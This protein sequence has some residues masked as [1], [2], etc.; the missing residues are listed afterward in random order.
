M[1]Q[2]GYQ[3]DIRITRIDDDTR[4]LPGVVE[5]NVLPGQTGIGALVHSVARREIGSQIWLAGADIDRVGIGGRQSDRA[6]RGDILRI[7]D[8][9]P[10]DTT[11]GC[12]PN[13]STDSAEVIDVRVPGN[14][15]DGNGAS[16]TKGAN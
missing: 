14:A 10:G 8:R 11:V 4:D 12:L 7:E 6:D 2:R 9:I 15:G 3:H 5:S 16:T 1:A 13:S